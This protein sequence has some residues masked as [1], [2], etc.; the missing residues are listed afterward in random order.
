MLEEASEREETTDTDDEPVG[1]RRNETDAEDAV[2][3]R[4][5]MGVS[6]SE[7]QEEGEEEPDLGGDEVAKHFDIRM[8]SRFRIDLR[9]RNGNEFLFQRRFLRVER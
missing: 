7:K 6:S 3:R 4:I 2:I 5:D 1:D 8:S 9:V